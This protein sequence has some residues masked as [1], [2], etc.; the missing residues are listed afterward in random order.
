MKQSVYRKEG[1]RRHATAKS[2]YSDRGAALYALLESGCETVQLVNKGG[3]SFLKFFQ[4][5]QKKMDLLRFHAV[6]VSAL[7]H[8]VG[9]ADSS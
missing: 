9:A 7:F 2:V 8:A 3:W 6:R 1:L 5:M 4:V